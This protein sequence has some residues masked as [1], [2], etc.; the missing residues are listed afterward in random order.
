MDFNFICAHC[1]ISGKKSARN[2]NTDQKKGKEKIYCDRKCVARAM[3]DKR[4][5]ICKLCGKEKYRIPSQ[6]SINTFCSKSCAVTY[7]N[8]HKKFGTRRSKL[9]R[10]I[11]DRVSEEFSDLD[12]RYNETAWIDYELD[13]YIPS[14]KTAIEING[15][16]HYQ[17]IYGIE[18]F[19]RI[20]TNDKMKADACLD[21]GIKLH[22]L[23]ISKNLHFSKKSAEPY[24][25]LVADIIKKAING[26]EEK[27]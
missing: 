2:L 15:I 12:A 24:Y 21:R 17:P 5:C 6:V 20:V 13:I 11:A 23:D 14:L 26:F 8:K 18:K 7:N 10:F 27:N 1:G 25:Q 9:E 4:L 3:T 16:F 22:I 19:N